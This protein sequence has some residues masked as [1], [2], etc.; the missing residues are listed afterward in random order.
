MRLALLSTV[1]LLVSCTGLD[2][3]VVDG[4][5]YTQGFT[6]GC[7]TAEAR[8]TSF[9][10]SVFRDSY[11]FKSEDSYAAGWRS[12]F[13]EC[14]PQGLRPLETSNEGLLSEPF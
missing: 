2:P 14:T 8:Q 1:C 7:R 13:A 3:E 12:G 4:P 11:L 6:D 5:Y 10:T 9:D